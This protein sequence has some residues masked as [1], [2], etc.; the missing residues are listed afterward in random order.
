MQVLLSMAVA[1][2]RSTHIRLSGA[3][4]VKLSAAST[5]LSVAVSF[6]APRAPGNTSSQRAELGE[7][8]FPRAGLQVHAG[9]GTHLVAAAAQA[10][11]VRAC[12][13]CLPL[14]HAQLHAQAC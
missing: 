4:T 2:C 6:G 1:H 10:M 11:R 13:A 5:A 9:W 12:Q 14:S 7:A 3:H 8:D